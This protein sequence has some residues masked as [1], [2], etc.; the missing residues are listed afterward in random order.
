MI[1]LEK[2]DLDTEAIINDCIVN[3][4]KEPVLS[5][6]KASKNFI[7]SKSREYDELAERGKLYTLKSHN[8]V[9]GGST[10]KEMIWFYDKKFVADGGRKYYNKIKAIPKYGKCPFCGVGIVST[11]DHYLPK[12]EYPTYAVTA[13]N[14]VAVCAGCNRNKSTAVSTKR[15]DELIHPYYDDFDDEVWLKSEILFDDKPIFR[16]YVEKPKTWSLEKYKR[17]EN[18]FEKMKLN[19]LYVSHG[20]EEF[21]EYEYQARKLYKVG[22][23]DLVKVDLRERVKERRS[24]TKNNWRAALYEGLLNNDN[25]FDKYLFNICS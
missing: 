9:P 13:C 21:S 20:V 17:A 16:F 1:K 8:L 3:I 4:K 18:H 19:F 6:I 7:V 15:E 12:T 2:P 5:H 14:L 22:G 25:F 23:K 10:K 11:L 24:I